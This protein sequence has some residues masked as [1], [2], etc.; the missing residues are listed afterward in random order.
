MEINFTIG[1][2]VFRENHDSNAHPIDGTFPKDKEA[3]LEKILYLKE[4]QNFVDQ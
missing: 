4:H 3:I 1:P 2:V